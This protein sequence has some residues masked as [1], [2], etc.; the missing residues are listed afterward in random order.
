MLN[1]KSLILKENKIQSFIN[2][3]Q[4]HKF[5][6]FL[7]GLGGS[8][9]VYLKLLI[10]YNIHPEYIIDNNPSITNSTYKNIQIKSADILN[11]YKSA[12]III[13]APSH[14]ESIISQVNNIS[15]DLTIVQFDPSLE[16][17]QN[18]SHEE[19]RAFYSQH[20]EELNSLYNLLNDDISK[21][22]FEK[23]IEGALTSDNYCYN[24]IATNN[25]YFPDII[26]SNLNESEV[27]LDVGAFIGDSSI[28]FINA[29]NNKFSK[30]IG[31]EP[32]TENIETALSQLNDDRIQFYPYGVGEKNET[33]YLYGEEGLD[34]FAHISEDKNDNYTEIK[35]ISIDNFIKDFIN[36]KYTYMKMDIEGMEVSALKGAAN[37]IR[38]YHPKLA[39]SIYHKL[40]D[41]ITIPDT[42]LSIDPSYKLYIRHYWGYCGTD[43]VLFA[44]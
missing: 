25:Q 22:T 28:E 6:V 30:I 36:E 33:L 7:F 13:S 26:M 2:I 41:F 38:E 39:I 44:I 1:I 31:F 21:N 11:E 15:K 37:T 5:P 14:A 43:T 34:D 18:V 8:I 16:I 4:D 20:S 3:Y 12:Y 23:I 19:R 35:I 10:K 32:K 24:Q 27:F 17:I 40:D 9:D 42:I 29:V